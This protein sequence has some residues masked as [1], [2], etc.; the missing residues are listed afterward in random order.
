VDEHGALLLKLR[1]VIPREL[2]DAKRERERE[3]EREL[4]IDRSLRSMR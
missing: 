1:S 3:R 2:N 4:R